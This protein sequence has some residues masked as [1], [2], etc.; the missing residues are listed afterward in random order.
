[1][2]ALTA[3]SAPVFSTTV[4]LECTQRR[5]H[6]Q[7]VHQSSGRMA[8]RG[9]LDFSRFRRAISA[10]NCLISTEVF[11]ASKAQSANKILGYSDALE[12]KRFISRVPSKLH[13]HPLQKSSVELTQLE[14]VA[15]E[16]PSRDHFPLSEKTQIQMWIEE[17]R[18]IFRSMGNGS[19]SAS[20]YDT[21]WVSL[22]PA[23]DGTKG[24]Q[25]P[26]SLQWLIE[27]QLED[28]SWGDPDFFSYSNNVLCTL[29]SIIALKTWNTG[30]QCVERGESFV[31]INL[32]RLEDEEYEMLCG[33]EIV[34]PT[35]LEDAKELGLDIPYD[36]PFFEKYRAAR[37]KKLQK[38]PLQLLYSSPTTILYSLEGV[39]D[40]IDW[41]QVLQFQQDD[42]SLLASPASTACA[43]LHTGNKKCLQYLSSVVQGFDHAAPSQY[44]LEIFERLW[45]VDRLERLGIARHFE[46]EIKTCLD[47]VYKYGPCFLFLTYRL[48]SFLLLVFLDSTTRVI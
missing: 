22:I 16:L 31:R 7:S 43:Y 8:G 1:M 41:E 26:G 47:Y 30:L 13:A 4:A 45:V 11:T 15:N 33:F 10:S 48:I 21:A 38:L 17:I 24:P 14:T 32:P 34:F 25:F 27:N 5:R 40:I 35:V 18:E 3:W 23:V 39:R 46:S 28:G 44:P 29:M 12:P 37:E 19:T 36:L 6:S 20:P 9:S 42:G 2:P